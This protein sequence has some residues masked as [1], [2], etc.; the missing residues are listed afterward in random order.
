MLNTCSVAFRVT[1]MMYPLG[2]RNLNINPEE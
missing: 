2:D 1:H